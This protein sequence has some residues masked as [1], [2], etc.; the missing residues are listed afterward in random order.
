[1]GFSIPHR[2]VVKAISKLADFPQKNVLDDDA[3]RPKSAG[4]LF[5][6]YR[7]VYRT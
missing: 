7:E 2:V 6:L 5:D 4:K 1:M 3:V